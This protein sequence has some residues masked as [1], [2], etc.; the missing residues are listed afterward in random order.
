METLVWAGAVIA[1]LGVVTLL[2]CVVIALRAKRA[3]LPDEELRE[4]LQKVVVINLGALAISAI[5][6]IMVIT[7]IMLG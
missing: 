5:G 2:Y 4:R 6:L 7:G 1:L 3:N